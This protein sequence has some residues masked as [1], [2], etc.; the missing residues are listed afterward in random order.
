VLFYT[1]LFI[2]CL[3][4]MFVILQLYRMIVGFTHGIPRNR[5]PHARQAQKAHLN[6]KKY[7]GNL[8][9][10]S[11]PRGW[12]G[13][14]RKTA[15]HHPGVATNHAATLNTNMVRKNSTGATVG[16]YKPNTTYSVH[17]GGSGLRG[18]AYKPSQDAISTFAIK[19]EN[20]EH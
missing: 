12:S 13:S 11:K 1:T 10:A 17:G 8:K 3:I 4:L 2:T 15:G 19:T 18:S 6:R 5:L 20:D 9:T 7:A 14:E 16:G